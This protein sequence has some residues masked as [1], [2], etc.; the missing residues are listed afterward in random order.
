MFNSCQNAAG[1]VLGLQLKA[2][3]AVSSV[4]PRCLFLLLLRLLQHPRSFC[5]SLSL[6][7]CLALQGMGEVQVWS[8]GQWCFLGIKHWEVLL[9]AQDLAVAM[10]I[11][12]SGVCGWHL[13][14]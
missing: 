3:S 1:L 11:F 8:W 14:E 10:G 6:W 4:L 13:S 9:G 2:Q 7:H 12:Q 5:F